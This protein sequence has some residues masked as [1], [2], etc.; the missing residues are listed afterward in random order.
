MREIVLDTET[1]GE[2]PKLGHRII[3][4]GCIE[5]IDGFITGKKYHQ[6]FNPE[7]SVEAVAKNAHGISTE[8]L[9]DKSLFKEVVN[10]IIR[11][12]GDS[13]M[14]AHNASFDISFLNAEMKL[15]GLDP[16]DK[17]RTIIDTLEIARKLFPNQKNNLNTLLDRF[18]LAAEHKDSRGVLLDAELLAKVYLE[19]KNT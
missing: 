10:E 12:I 11:F 6:Y 4:L 3:E 18:N 1:T 16:I 5:V 17:E 9:N 19:L 2:N 14:V 8:C 7:R 13:T 15:N